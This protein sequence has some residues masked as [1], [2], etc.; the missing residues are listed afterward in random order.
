VVKAGGHI[1][2]CP[3]TAEGEEE[4]HARLVSSDWGYEFS[5]YEETD[6][7]KRRYWKRV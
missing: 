3:G 4:Q 1:I 6:G 5:R 2:H 7:W